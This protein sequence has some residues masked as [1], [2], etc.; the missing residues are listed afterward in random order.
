MIAAGDAAAALA[1]V[2][3]PGYA[4]YLIVFLRLMTSGF[5]QSHADE[6]VHFIDGGRSVK[7][8]C[9]TDVDPCDREADHLQVQALARALGTGL[10][11]AYLDRVRSLGGGGRSPFPPTRRTLAKKNQKKK[12]T[13]RLQTPGPAVLHDVLEGTAPLMHLLYRPGHFDLLYQS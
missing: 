9:N 13:T 5:L 2:G 8:F 11:V 4:S 7:D 6:F 10:R 1:N 12:L 3:E